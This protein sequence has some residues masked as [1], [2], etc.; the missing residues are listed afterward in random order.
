MRLVHG[1]KWVIKNLAVG[2]A[3]SRWLFVRDGPK[4]R[5]GKVRQER[6]A[7]IELQPAHAAMVFQIFS[8]ARFVD[9]E[10]FGEFFFQVRA[11]AAASTAAQ[12]VPDAHAQRL[13]RFGVI[14]S[15]LV[16]VRDEEDA[17]P[18]GRLVGLL[19]R[20]DRT[21]QKAAKLRLELRHAR[22]K[23]GIARANARRRQ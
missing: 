8:D 21:S 2:G 13:A 11:F 1:G 17:G 5:D 15:G 3:K 14:V 16:R 12:H 4:D 18:G 23:R 7:L 19:E 9:A 20:M 10:M 6:R 22:G